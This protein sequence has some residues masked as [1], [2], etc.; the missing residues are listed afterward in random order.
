FTQSDFEGI[1]SDITVVM[2]YKDD[3]KCKNFAKAYWWYLDIAL[4]INV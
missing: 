2:T 4:D 3:I 1:D